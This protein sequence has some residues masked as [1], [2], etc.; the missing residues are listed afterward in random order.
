M[1][2]PTAEYP[3]RQQPD[4]APGSTLQRSGHRRVSACGH[5][6]GEALIAGEELIPSITREGD[7]HVASGDLAEQEGRHRT[8]VSEWL[9]VVPHEAL[10]EVHG[11]RMDDVLMVI[12]AVSVS[13][14]AR[15]RALVEALPVLKADGERLHRAVDQFG[16]QSDHRGRVDAATE[17]G[18]HRYVGDKPAAYG[19]AE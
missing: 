18:A 6:S 15:V 17:E 4:R 1:C 14:L 11:V 19:L 5:A 12:G 7:R 8:R 13:R 16:H 3:V 2:P 9:V 10:D